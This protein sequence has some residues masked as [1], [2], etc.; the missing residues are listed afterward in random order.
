M[1]LTW[2]KLAES[3]EEIPWNAN[4]LAE[5]E[6]AGRSFCLARHNG[7]VFAIAPKCPHASGRMAGGVID[8]QGNVVCPLHRY[9][10]CL[11]N[12]RNVSGEGYFLKHFPLEWREDGLYVGLQKGFL[13]IF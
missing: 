2:H 3:I 12:G 7:Q 11:S 1:N 6:A 5:I 9:K 13:G 8:G 10:F 4:N